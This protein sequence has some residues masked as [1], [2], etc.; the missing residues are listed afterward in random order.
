[1]GN[2]EPSSAPSGEEDREKKPE[3]AVGDGNEQGEVAE[4]GVEDSGGLKFFS[5]S[6]PRDAM[7]G[8]A[9]GMGN[10]AKGVFGGLTMMVAAPIQG[11]IEGA[12]DGGGTLGATKGAAMGLGIG[13]VGGVAT[14]VYGVGS[15]LVQ[16]G[17]GLANAPGAAMARSEGCDW[18]DELKQWVLYDLKVDAET[19]MSMDEEDF[20]TQLREKEAARKEA[21]RKAAIDAGEDPDQENSAGASPPRKDVKVKDTSLYD[22]LGVAPNASASDIKKAYYVAARKN[23]PDRNKDD[24]EANAKFQKIGTAYQ[25]LSDEKSRADYDLG[26][27]DA[28]EDGATKMDP[29]ALFAIIFGSELFEPIMGE[30]KL[31]SQMRLGIASEEAMRDSVSS[32]DESFGSDFNGEVLKFIQKQR[33]VK[34]ALNLTAKLDTFLDSFANFEKGDE[35]GFR[36]AMEREA[37]ELIQNPIGSVL[38]STIGHAYLEWV[39]VDSGGTIDSIAVGMKQASRNAYAKASIGY[40]GVKSVVGGV[41]LQKMQDKLV[42]GKDK[43]QDEE[44]GE[45][46]SGSAGDGDGSSGDKD[47]EAGAEGRESEKRVSLSEDEEKI[48]AEK[49]AKTLNNVILIMWRVTELDIRSTIAKICKK[50]T[51][52][53]SV[54]DLARERRMRALQLIGESYI[55]LTPGNSSYGASAADVLEMMT[56]I[57]QQAQGGAPPEDEVRKEE[58]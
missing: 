1:M 11:G 32:S 58:K 41:E 3:V 19:M 9:K 37:G 42:E 28:V 24:P 17:R 44:G 18:D 34:C 10:I 39:R 21:A 40:A 50:V 38:V 13:I 47:D 30:L 54:D 46:S 53:H 45:S 35:T 2:D 5:T 43:G 31:A 7:D 20:I 25:I 12:K 6:R 23:H 27:R 55:K 36:V 48:L 4:E 14:A 51:H 15:G 33:A 8:A 52:D 56:P 16:V 26:G 29:S 57:L 49:M 22:A